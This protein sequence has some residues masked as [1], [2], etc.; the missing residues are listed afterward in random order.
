MT[1]VFLVWMFSATAVVAQEVPV[2]P[3]VEL[4]DSARVY[5]LTMLPG[6][7]VYSKFGHSA[8]RILDDSTGLDKTYN[9]G[10]FEFNQPH[11]VLRFLRGNL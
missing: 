3:R 7:Q 9:Y 6:D 11:F 8:I 10:T 2:P 4:S 5:L 1:R